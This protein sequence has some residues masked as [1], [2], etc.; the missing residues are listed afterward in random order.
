MF[1]LKPYNQ[2]MPRLC[3]RCTIKS[4]SGKF[5]KKSLT[6]LSAD[7]S[8][9]RKMSVKIR[10]RNRERQRTANN[11]ISGGQA[12]ESEAVIEDEAEYLMPADIEND[13]SLQRVRSQ[14]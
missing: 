2:A 13:N 9:Y 7:M 4:K 14:D 8:V 12:S 3:F 10:E 6:P 11:A 1:K 5:G